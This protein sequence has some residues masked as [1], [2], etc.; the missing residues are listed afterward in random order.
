MQLSRALFDVGILTQQREAMLAFWHDKLGLAITQELYPVNGVAQYK[1]DLKGAVLKLNCVDVD[2]PANNLDNGLRLLLIADGRVEAPRQ[3]KD[4]D[5]NRVCLIPPGYR[6]I[7]RFAVHFSVSNERSFDHFYGHIC[8]LP[9]IADRTYDCAGAAISFSWSPDVQANVDT[10]G[11][12]YYYLTFQALD[13]A[14]EHKAL[15]ERG[16]V[17]DQPVSD[18]HTTTGSIISFILDPDGN[19]IELSQRE[20]LVETFHNNRQ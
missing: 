1:L 10:T 11:I 20:D 14:A 6:G 8:Q 13:A 5:G 15:C 2:L 19:K 18:S 3:L 17:E 9:K 16:A 4:P 7:D 12:G